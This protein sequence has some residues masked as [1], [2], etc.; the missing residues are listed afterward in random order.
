M[1]FFSELLIAG[2]SCFPRFVDIQV[3]TDESE[4]VLVTRVPAAVIPKQYQVELSVQMDRVPTEPL[5]SGFKVT[6]Q[7]CMDHHFLASE[8][9]RVSL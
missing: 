3:E 2:L 4:A 5:E 9:Q 1:C 8:T 6:L 7:N